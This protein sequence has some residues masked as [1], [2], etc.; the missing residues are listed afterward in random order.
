MKVQAV[1]KELAVKVLDNDGKP[2]YQVDCFNEVH[3]WYCVLA[4]YNMTNGYRG[5]S[6]NSAILLPA[7][8]KGDESYIRPLTPEKE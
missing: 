7:G 2:L 3:F 1:K 4:V 5:Y 8:F 6:P